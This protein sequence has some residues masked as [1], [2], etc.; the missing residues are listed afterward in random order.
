MRHSIKF[1]KK[2]TKTKTKLKHNFSSPFKI[3]LNDIDS[4][5]F[6]RKLKKII[7]LAMSGKTRSKTIANMQR[8]VKNIDSNRTYYG[9]LDVL[10]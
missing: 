5:S 6:Y 9:V 2:P 1:F 4:L 7:L 3:G 10:N 8:N